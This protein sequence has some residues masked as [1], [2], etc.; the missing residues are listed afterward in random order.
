MVNR[1]IQATVLVVVVVSA[2]FAGL[3]YTGWIDLPGLGGESRISS[4]RMCGNTSDVLYPELM[5]ATF[6]PDSFGGWLV[7]ASFVNDS[8]GPYNATLYDASFTASATEVEDINNALHDGLSQTYASNDSFAGEWPHIAFDML[9]SYKDGTWIYVI[10]FLTVKGHIMT[11]S[12]SGTPDTQLTS[13]LLEP[14]SALDGLI[15]AINDVFA[16]YLG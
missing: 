7:T 11:R 6:S 8:L 13:D 9:I 4:I 16:K 2:A 3:V 5:D 1:G 12:G 15:L 14:G 10:K